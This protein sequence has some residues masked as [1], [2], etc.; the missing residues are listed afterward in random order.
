MGF[1]L[2]ASGVTGENFVTKLLSFAGTTADDEYTKGPERSKTVLPNGDG[3]YKLALTVKGES[4]TKISKANVIVVMDT[5]GS[6]DYSAG[7]VYTSSSATDE[8]GMYGL[9]DDEY[10]AL[11]RHG[12]KNNY[13][14]T[15]GDNVSYTGTRYTRA[16]S[17][18]KR[19]AAAKT[20][21]NDLANS[22]LSLNGQNG[23]PSDTFEMALVSFSNSGAV[24]VGKTTSYSTFQSAVNALKANGGTNW[25]SALETAYGL[26]FNDNDQT[27]IIF[28]SDG[29]PTFRDTKGEWSDW[30]S[31][32]QAYG[33]GSET[34][35]NIARSYKYAL[36][37]AKKIVNS[38]KYILYSIGAYGSV[39]RM[40]QLMSESGAGVANYFSAAETAQLQAAVHLALEPPPRFHQ[41]KSDYGQVDERKST[42]DVQCLVPVTIHALAH[43]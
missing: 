7:Y 1:G 9:V 21:V 4:V 5:S 33:T 20:A 18:T 36:V 28:V 39:D 43:I 30:N 40:Q 34:D 15:Y 29:N 2:R 12:K 25:E 6:M 10:V 26:S 42:E 32:Y 8:H 14:W 17:S 11:T 31:T 37:S 24:K 19:L 16:E 23:N 3:S 13:T 38:N 22:L 35:E 27:Y 41:S